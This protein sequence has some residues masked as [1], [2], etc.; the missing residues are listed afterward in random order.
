MAIRNLKYTSTKQGIRK[1]LNGCFAL[2]MMLSLVACGE[3][4]IVL[5]DL[6]QGT[7]SN[8]RFFVTGNFNYWDPGDRHYELT[9][10]GGNRYGITLPTGWG[11][12]EYKITRGDWSTEEVDGCGKP[13][14]NRVVDHQ[15]NDTVKL[16]VESWKD[17]G[18]V[19]CRQITLLVTPPPH[20]PVDDPIYIAGNFNNWEAGNPNYR[21]SRRPDGLYSLTLYKGLQTVEY[22][23]TRGVWE[24]EEMGPFGDVAENRVF[25]YGTE[26]TLHLRI[27][28]WKDRV[29]YGGD[30]VYLKVLVPP[31]TPAGQ[32]LF[33]A[34]NF[35]N[36]QAGHPEFKLRRMA[37]GSFAGSF[38]VLKSNTLTEFKI[39]RG[40]WES[41][42]VSAQGNNVANH[43][44]SKSIKDTVYL[45]VKGWKDFF[46]K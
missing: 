31:S 10:L 15:A 44:F 29:H 4:T 20:S 13:V 22:K 17:L 46:L 23:F 33:V 41:V 43:A 35:N 2:L 6:P 11:K 42:E 32:N 9:P 28:F 40:T 1:W 37:D 14:V 45:E 30:S 18:L 12:I 7:P 3:V 26:D 39:T 38:R 16:R 24:A 27:P 19:N 21:L 8:S 25:S 5:E 36:W 34:G